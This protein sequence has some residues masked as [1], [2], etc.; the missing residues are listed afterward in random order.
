MLHTVYDVSNILTDAVYQ[1][2][3]P[4]VW[5]VCRDETQCAGG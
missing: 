2:F 4:S 1:M 5:C 3:I